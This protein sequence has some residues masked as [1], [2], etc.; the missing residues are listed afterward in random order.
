MK[1]ES[2]KWGLKRVGV[3]APALWGARTILNSGRD[4]DSVDVVWDRQGVEGEENECRVLL[5]A[6]N[7]GCLQAWRKHCE[8]LFIDLA[9]DEI[10]S[11]KFAGVEFAFSPQ[12]SYG[13]V[14]VTAWFAAHRKEG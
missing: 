10:M 3:E 9:S 14:Y 5:T 11:Y 13:Y 12:R 2:L 8:K 4:L 7:G 6:L 1:S